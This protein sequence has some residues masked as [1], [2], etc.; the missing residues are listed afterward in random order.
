MNNVK[1]LNN[2]KL[3]EMIIRRDELLKEKPELAEL[4]F[5]INDILA[6][7]GTQQNKNILLRNLMLDSMNELREKLDDLQVSLKSLQDKCGK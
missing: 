1:E 7:A 5:K 3:N 2:S 6:G 4:Q